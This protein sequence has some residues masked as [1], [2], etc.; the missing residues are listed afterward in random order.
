MTEPRSI[1]RGTP[2][3]P[4]VATGFLVPFE[5]AEPPAAGSAVV[6]D[7]AVD[8]ELALFEEAVALVIADLERSARQLTEEGLTGEAAIFEA[9]VLVLEDAELRLR[10]R[11]IV[12]ESHCAA[13][14]AVAR[15]LSR[16]AATLRS[17]GAG[18][19]ND[20]ADDLDDLGQH[21]RDTLHRDLEDD[22]AERLAATET[23]VLAVEAMT[24]SQVLTAHG[25]GARALLTAR[26]TGLSHAA[27]LARSLRIPM[28]RVPRLRSLSRRA[29]AAVRVDADQGVVEVA[30]PERPIEVTAASHRGETPATRPTDSLP[31]PC[32]LWLSVV[33]PDE[34][35]GLDWSDATGVGLYRTETLFLAARDFPT[36]DEQLVHYRALIDAADGRPVTIRTLDLGGDKTVPYLRFGP[37]SNPFLGLR[38]HRL[39]RFHPELLLT[40]LRAILRAAAGA[41]PVSILFPMVGSVEEWRRLRDRVREAAESLRA[42]GVEHRNRLDLGVLVETPAAA[43]SLQEILAEADFASVG[44]NDLVQFLFAAERGNA[45]VADDYR[46]EHPVVLALLAE[47]AQVARDAGK[48]L[49]LCGEIAGDPDLAPLLVGLGLERLSVSLGAYG[50]VRE[51]LARTTATGC[52]ELARSALAA[53]TAAEVREVLERASPASPGSRRSDGRRHTEATIDPVCGMTVDPDTTPFVLGQGDARVA[54]CSARCLDLYQRRQ[55]GDR[56]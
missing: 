17:R 36:E 28:L 7:H 34:L 48:P 39:F 49:S 25:H 33:H 52:R 31:L 18:H 20:R 41:G 12:R 26:G 23:P 37:G 16:L 43:L 30:T 47:L 35:D 44:T 11:E 3:A 29:G 15:E 56:S 19:W 53:T 8:H 13:G 6:P 22:L 45:D 2:L 38:A 10:V 9:Q 32:S 40:Q 14:D 27:I 54:F 51:R 55:A 24:P 46:P 42:D 5:G 21:I 1:V 50:A 4:G